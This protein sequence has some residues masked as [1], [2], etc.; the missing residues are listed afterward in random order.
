M[1]PKHPDGD[2][3]IDEEEDEFEWG[4]EEFKE[5]KELKNQRIQRRQTK[6]YKRTRYKLY[7]K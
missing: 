3:Y 2:N 6:L 4:E 7:T 1:N 5:L